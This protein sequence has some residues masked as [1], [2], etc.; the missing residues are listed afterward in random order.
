M[1]AAIHR[2]IGNLL[3]VRSG[4]IVH[5]C[6]ALGVMGAGVALAVRKKYPGAFLVYRDQ[7]LMTGLQVGSIIPYRVPK[8]A[9]EPALFIVNAVT[10]QNV[11]T[12]QRQVDYEGLGRCFNKIA[13]FAREQNID[14]VHFPLIGCG[15]AG[16]EWG[17]IEPIIAEELEGL[18]ANLWV[19]E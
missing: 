2:R 8:L 12:R 10:Q 16:G 11:G 15:L 9:G 13:T 18:N 6:N 19:L 7:W 14:E 17:V 1:A 3:S 5:G 4:I